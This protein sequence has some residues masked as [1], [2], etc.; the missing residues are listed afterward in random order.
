MVAVPTV[1][2]VTNPFTTVAT[3]VLLLLHDT[4]V[5]FSYAGAT[6]TYSTSV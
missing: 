2:A 3:A 6:V 4:F 1:F 5:L